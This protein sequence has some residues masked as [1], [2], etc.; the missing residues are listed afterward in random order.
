[1][2]AAVSR[3]VV[4]VLARFGAAVGFCQTYALPVRW[5]R[6]PESRW[7]ERLRRR[8]STLL[9]AVIDRRAGPRPIA[10][11]EYAGR[12]DGSLAEAERLLYDEGFVRNPLS[13]LKT[14]G[15]QAERGSWAYRE[16]PLAR[17]QL[18]VMLFPDGAGVDVY[19]HEEPSS[20]NPVA[21]GAHLN[22]TTQHVAN[23]VE[24][25]RDRL[26]LETTGAPVDPPEGPWDSRATGSTSLGGSV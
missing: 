7:W 8:A 26:P 11:G 16:S 20:V 17:R 10:D 5:N 25:A 21:S 12:F 3:L 22:G 4:T 14:R 19:A 18:H 23:G 15:G 9:G 6:G 13:R 24:R 1:M 2:M